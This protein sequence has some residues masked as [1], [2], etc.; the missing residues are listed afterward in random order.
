[1]TVLDPI[2]SG[3]YCNIEQVRNFV[4]VPLDR[5]SDGQLEE[6]ILDQDS[7]LDDITGRRW[8]EHIVNDEYHD[9][10]AYK[11]FVTSHYPIISVTTLE[12]YENDA[13]VAKTEWDP[14][15]RTGDFRVVKPESGIIEWI[16]TPPSSGKDKI[17]LTYK[18]G[19]ETVPRKIQDL[20]IRLASIAAL[21]VD[22]GQM[23]PSGYKSISEGSLSI[24]WGNGA[25]DGRIQTLAQQVDIKLKQ[26]G[27]KL[28]YAWSQ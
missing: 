19:E 28:K 4:G 9:G 3:G 5:V 16:N 24:S 1:M 12:V 6:I 8:M 17:R 20:S 21:Q 18:A 22:A 10:D 27:G 11:R 14:V 2:P 25:H 13:W 26:L 15:A 23:N 7:W